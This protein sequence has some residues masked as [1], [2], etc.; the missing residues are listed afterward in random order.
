MD[1]RL[2]RNDSP[3]R[4]HM[5]VFT[6]AGRHG[7]VRFSKTL[8]THKQ[9]PATLTLSDAAFAAPRVKETAAERRARFKALS[10]AEKL[11]QLKSRIVRMRAR[12]TAQPAAAPQ[13]AAKRRLRPRKPRPRRSER[14]SCHAHATKQRAP[15]RGAPLFVVPRL[16][17]VIVCRLCHCLPTTTSNKRLT[18]C[19]TMSWIGRRSQASSESSRGRAPDCRPRRSGDSVVAIEHATAAQE[20]MARAQEK[21]NERI[22]YLEIIGIVVA[23][24]AALLAVVQ[25]WVAL[26]VG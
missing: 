4:S 16:A 20:R 17:N 23:L 25:I 11:A 9:A 12:L 15:C 10:P 13:K 7:S 19:M 1:I 21:T 2:T 5:V 3:R 6:V 18:K 26:R 8:F 14:S 22:M 24:A